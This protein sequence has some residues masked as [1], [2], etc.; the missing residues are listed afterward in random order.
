MYN[1]EQVL[2]R[3]KNENIEPWKSDIELATER[4][5]KNHEF[6]TFFSILN[7]TGVSVKKKI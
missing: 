5:K 1:T 6:P 3:A 7:S 2:E 4:V